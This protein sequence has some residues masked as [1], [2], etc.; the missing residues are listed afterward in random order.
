M[1][2]TCAIVAALLLAS[3]C[4]V[5]AQEVDTSADEIGE[6]ERPAASG[7]P[8]G[9]MLDQ[10]EDAADVG[11]EP[12][13]ER[14]VR[15]SS[16]PLVADHVDIPEDDEADAARHALAARNWAMLREQAAAAAAG[17]GQVPG[18]PTFLAGRCAVSKC[19]RSIV[20]QWQNH[21]SIF[22]TSVGGCC[23]KCSINAPSRPRCCRSA[24]PSTDIL[25]A[26]VEAGN[27]F[28]LSFRTL[29]L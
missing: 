17:R 18:Y 15:V 8:R 10:G 26:G 4:H 13:H 23:L 28:E 5:H 14:S 6:V 3:A 22:P 27:R 29:I 7:R 24:G 21:S 2:K 16:Q 12:V 25:A 1:K 9:P 19:T 20:K 11:D